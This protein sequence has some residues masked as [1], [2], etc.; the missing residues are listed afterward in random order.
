[1]QI[2]FIIMA[3]FTLFCAV[4]VVITRKMM[5]AALWLVGTLFGVAV[6]FA[7]LE[8][9][10]FAVA[11]VLVYIGAISILIIFAIML[12][13]KVMLDVGPQVNRNWIWGAVG[14]IGMFVL[15]VLG[16][17]NWPKFSA[18]TQ[19]LAQGDIISEFGKALVDPNGFVI[20]FEVASI[21]LL[22]A[23]IGAIFV[24]AELRGGQS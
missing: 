7:L 8:A 22:A 12:I 21:L 3:G 10:F 9:G 14:S 19:P 15:M 18:V 17:W 23:L 2:I 6:L 11:Q 16:L 24:A 4:R 1:M 13:R 5:H 20:P